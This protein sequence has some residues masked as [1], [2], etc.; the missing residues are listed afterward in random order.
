MRLPV[1]RQIARGPARCRCRR[2]PA[3]GGAARTSSAPGQAPARPDRRRTAS[4]AR[5]RP[6][7]PLGA[8]PIS[9]DARGSGA[10]APREGVESGRRLAGS[11]PGRRCS[12]EWTGW[13]TPRASSSGCARSS[14]ARAPARAPR[15]DRR[16]ADRG[17]EPRSERAIPGAPRR[18]R[19]ARR[20]H[21]RALHL[22]GRRRPVHYLYRGFP[23]PSWSRTTRSADVCW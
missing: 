2:L 9:I 8:F 23:G 18:G 15:P 16:S 7:G 10:Q 5:R 11:E 3:D 14:A 17:P 21:Q 13:T 20:P 12:S 19:A 4:P 22:S 1:A 6:R